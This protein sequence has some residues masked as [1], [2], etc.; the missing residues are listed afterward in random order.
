MEKVKIVEHVITF[1]YGTEHI[2]SLNNV[3]CI[4]FQLKYASFEVDNFRFGPFDFS[5][6][7]VLL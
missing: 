4:Y 1:S 2:Q 5:V 3:A 7:K 6:G